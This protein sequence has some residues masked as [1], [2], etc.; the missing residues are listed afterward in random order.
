M[1]LQTYFHMESV[2]EAYLYKYHFH[3]LQCHNSINNVLKFYSTVTYTLAD[4]HWFKTALIPLAPSEDG[5]MSTKF[6]SVCPQLP[7]Q[8]ALKSV[9]SSCVYKNT[10]YN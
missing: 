10:R 8:K 6:R 1:N 9:A 4:L 7:L 5:H 2:G 3:N